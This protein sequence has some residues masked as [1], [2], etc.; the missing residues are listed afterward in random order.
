MEPIALTLGQQFDLEQRSRDI[1]TITDERTSGDQQRSV[2][3]IAEG[4]RTIPG[5]SLLTDQMTLDYSRLTF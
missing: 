4:D 5:R 2:A 1:S 3:G